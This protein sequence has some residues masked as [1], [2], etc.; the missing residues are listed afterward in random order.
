[1]FLSQEKIERIR[2]IVERGY[3]RL[4]LEVVG[5][6]ALTDTQKQTLIDS[7]IDISNQPDSLLK[8]LYFNHLF[9]MVDG[10]NH[11][12]QTASE[13]KSQS[14]QMI[15]DSERQKFVLNHLNQN[16]TNQINKLKNDTTSR[17]QTAITNSNLEYSNKIV[18][19][20]DSNKFIKE[21]HVANLKTKLNDIRDQGAKE[22]KRT[23]V[24]ELSN[25]ISLGGVD[26]VLSTNENKSPSEIYVYKLIVQDNKTCSYCKKFF[27]DNDGTPALYR[28]SELLGNGTNIGKKQAEWLPVT[29]PIHIN[30]RETSIIELPKGFKVDFGGQMTYIGREEWE[31]YLQ[32]KLR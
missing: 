11:T 25:A 21:E 26:R 5:G 29:G 32:R 15:A 13:L 18:D 24:T 30:C 27:Q 16:L 14:H 28:L 9:N 7:G 6:A 10:K 20:D 17:V 19:Q 4:V 23:S 3:A 22:W 1:M 2:Q 31:T 12:P 8:L